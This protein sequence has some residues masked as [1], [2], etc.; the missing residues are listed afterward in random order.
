MA[1]KYDIQEEPLSVHLEQ[2]G[3]NAHLILEEYEFPLRQTKYQTQK[4]ELIVLSAKNEDRLQ[5]YIK[6]IINFL[7]LVLSRKNSFS[8]SFNKGDLDQFIEPNF[9]LGDLAYTLQVGREPMEERLAVIVN[10]LEALQE[11]LTQYTQGQSEIEHFYQGNIKTSKVDSELLNQGDDLKKIGTD[12]DG[13]IQ[14][15]QQWVSGIEINWQSVSRSH[16]QSKRIALP[17]YPFERRRCWVQITPHSVSVSSQQKAQQSEARVQHSFSTLDYL[18][19]IK[20]VSDKLLP[21]ISLIILSFFQNNQLLKTQKKI[22]AKKLKKKLGLI[23]QYEGLF[24]FFLDMLHKNGLIMTVADSHKI[25]LTETALS[26]NIQN[27]LN[28]L[29]ARQELILRAFPEFDSH[30]RLLAF[31]QQHYSSVLQGSSSAERLFISREVKKWIEAV[32]QGENRLSEPL[33][34]I[35]S[36]RITHYLEKNPSGTLRILE[37]GAGTQVIT[38]T[39]F[40]TLSANPIIQTML[41]Y[42]SDKPTLL[43]N[44]RQEMLQ[45]SYPLLQFQYIDEH[46]LENIDTNE[47]FDIIVLKGILANKTATFKHL[48]K[49]IRTLVSANSLLFIS[50]PNE[51]ELN[52]LPLSFGLLDESWLFQSTLLNNIDLK[53]ILHEADFIFE[54]VAGQWLSIAEPQK[55]T[56]DNTASSTQIN[57]VFQAEKRKRQVESDLISLFSQLLGI[58]TKEIKRDIDVRDYGANS[59]I[60]SQ[61]FTNLQ[62]KYGSE[63]TPQDV[64]I[65]TTISSLAEFIVTE[66]IV[67][68]N[69]TKSED[70]K[71]TSLF[72]DRENNH[73]NQHDEDSL[74][75][76]SETTP[77]V[78]KQNTIPNIEALLKRQTFTTS[79]GHQLEFFTCGQ[80]KPVM[81]LTALAFTRGIWQFQIAAFHNEYQLIF[82]HLPGH[83]KS[84]TQGQFSFEELADDFVELLNA[85]KIPAIHLV[86][87]CMAGNIGQLL[88]YRHPQRVKTLTLVATTPTDA[89]LRGL[90]ADDLR[91]YSYSPLSTYELEFQNIF[92]Q[93]SDKKSLMAY[94]LDI[95]KQHYCQVDTEAV[96]H[97]INNLFQFDATDNLKEILAPTLVIAGKWDIA[98]PP[99]QVQLLHQGIRRSKFFEFE[100]AGHLPFLTDHESFNR[101]FREF[102]VAN[103]E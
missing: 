91:E 52:Y 6:K 47:T 36:E 26:Q 32:Y 14:L 92:Q 11:K 33:K 42:C 58:S 53:A 68:R 99:A 39:I 85:L 20:Q 41:F 62:N 72:D 77:F 24:H 66:F 69:Y 65:H 50:Q 35:I 87:W 80:G 93:H 46:H 23:S 55:N 48:I 43:R 51:L 1:K 8:S 73:G 56:R 103:A 61:V 101:I 38:N 98:F 16:N 37:M 44:L 34:P 89:R 15:A 102:L 9:L 70:N 5:A 29:N 86:G 97:Y 30:L 100:S 22:S 60:F 3:A 21:F 90:N 54:E 17:T 71:Y 45:Q 13:L 10:S 40:E 96:L 27:S 31:C 18:R 49:T 84:G 94:Y 95:I 4:D 12:K 19:N 81:F 78:S 67:E 63:I 2:G 57:K 64:L 79:L 88:A 75:L 74:L 76:Y 82:P 7:N 59:I 83:G 25:H 28:G